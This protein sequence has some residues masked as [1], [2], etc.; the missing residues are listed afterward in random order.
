MSL[1]QDNIMKSSLETT[2]KLIL[3]NLPFGVSLQDK[4]RIIFFE[5]KKAKEL[6]GSFHTR[7]C[8]HR[9]QYLPNEGHKVCDNCPAVMSLKDKQAHK[10]YRKTK[11]RNLE[12]LLLEFYCIPLLD[13][14]GEVTK[15]I[16][17]IKDVTDQ[18]KAQILSETNK[19][20]I[21]ESEL[22]FSFRNLS[23][24]NQ[25]TDKL[26][27]FSDDVDERLKKLAAYTYIG[28]V[29]NEIEHKGLFGPLPVL[30]V[31]DQ[32]MLA[33]SFSLKSEKFESEKKKSTFC[34]IFIFFDKKFTSFFE[35]RPKISEYLENEIEEFN[36]VEELSEKWFQ[37]LKKGFKEL[38]KNFE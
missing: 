21:I 5:N 30:D 16:E 9:W 28:I 24:E 38:I 25:Y 1:E 6:L 15:Y 10:I 35:N 33:Y 29:Q 20:K 32:Y 36:F 3:D 26:D 23:G 19:E 14:N 27:F 31:L 8:F 22:K 17:I 11:S 37:D 4:K 12:D 34:V 7:P 18:E 13:E 2:Y